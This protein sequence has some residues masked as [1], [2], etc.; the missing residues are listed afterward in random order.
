MKI[1]GFTRDDDFLQDH[2]VSRLFPP[3]GILNNYKIHNKINSVAFSPQG[4]I[5]T[6]R[7]P[8]VSEIQCQLLR[9]EGCRVVSTADPLVR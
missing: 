3:L 8:L 5:P 6:E 2:W 7:P 4:T 1:C 9:I